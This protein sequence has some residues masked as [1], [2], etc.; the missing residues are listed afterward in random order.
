MG[1]VYKKELK[2]YFSTMTGYIFIAFMLLMCG[3]FYTIYNIKNL[4]PNF[5]YS[6]DSISYIFLLIVPILT[7]KSI[8]DEKAQK[9]D[10]LLL[11]LPVSISKIIIGKYLALLTVF[12][13]PV[14]IMCFYPLILSLFGN[15]NYATTYG[16][17]LGFFLFG[18]S[19]LAIGLFISSI[20]ESQIIAA[21]L[22][23]GILLLA[24]SMGAISLL[25]PTTAIASL[26][27]FTIVSVIFGIIVYLT[28]KNMAV[29]LTTGVL[30]QAA[31]IV[32]Y[33]IDSSKFEGSFSKV[34]DCF[35]ISTMY[36]GFTAGLFDLTAI[37]YYVSVT[38][39]F[40]FF[41]IR[42]LEKKR[43]N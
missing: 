3:I 4:S 9:T 40:I 37:V 1:A 15:V 41:G 18:A 23:F 43:W 32:L 2:T 20:T 35:K 30:S 24:Y 27:A 38:A 8:A 6:L 39:L 36:Q 42:S 16:S 14:V 10:Q 25:I 29:G 5:E 17:I 33:L 12:T 22:C 26:I 19:L 11:S 13:I 34:L 31:V 21:V 28:T 7:M